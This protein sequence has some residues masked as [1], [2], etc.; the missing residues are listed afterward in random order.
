MHWLG[1][2]TVAVPPPICWIPPGTGACFNPRLQFQ[3]IIASNNDAVES[4]K[5]SGMGFWYVC[6]LT[7]E[8][9]TTN[10]LQ[11][12]QLPEPHHLGFISGS[13]TKK[14]GLAVESSNN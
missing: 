7:T 2:K 4:S 6:R 5:A 9:A 14:M 8:G 10:E 13:V 1:K 12:D 11:S 3:I